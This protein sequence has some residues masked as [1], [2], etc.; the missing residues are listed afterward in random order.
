[1]YKIS[2]SEMRNGSYGENLAEY[3]C[4]L[5]GQYGQPM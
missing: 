3:N 4:I 2:Y 1:M 5:L